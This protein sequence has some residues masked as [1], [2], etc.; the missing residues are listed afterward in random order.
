MIEVIVFVLVLMGALLAW[1]TISAKRSMAYVF[2]NA[3]VSA[4][5]AKLLS[6]ARL[7]EL[8]ET[9][10]ITNI[11][12]ALDETEYRPQ[13]TEIQRGG[14]VDMIAVEK[15]FM[16]NLNM[17]YSELLSMVPRERKDIVMKILQRRDLMNLKTIVTMIHE[18]VPPEQRIH[19]LVPSPTMSQERLEMLASAEDFNELLEFLKGSEYFDVVAGSL[20]DYEK[21]GITAM[22][23]ALDMNYYKNLWKEVLKKRS[24][25]SILKSMIGY[26]IDS[27]N[28]KLILRLKQENARPEEIEKR[29]IRPSH[30][31]TEEMLKAMIT[32][33]DIRSAIHMIRI[34]TPG[35]VLS[36]AIT[37]IERE[38]VQA[39]ERALDEG[40]L[41]LC[42]WLGLTKFFSIAP[43]ISYIKQKE[44][45]VK[46][47][48]AIIRLKMDGFQPQ[49]IKEK[50]VR[51]PKIEL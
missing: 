26:E 14:E 31:L 16:E 2:C 48:R 47:L 22:I 42:R 20:E 46:N 35:S 40:H 51:V 34:T 30:E 33:N 13:F 1:V 41:K 8:V 49:K 17:R 38:G 21:I 4:W 12:S 43:V 5:E 39:A 24:Q 45:E 37:Q 19:H 10:S 25:R 6:E 28:I 50:M 3:T 36:N 18:K 27:A 9:Q 7:M 23:S 11:F 44:A 29:L 15:A 32:A